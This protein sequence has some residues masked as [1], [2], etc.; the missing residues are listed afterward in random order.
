[1]PNITWYFNNSFLHSPNTRRRVSAYNG[2]ISL[3]DILN[4]TE[5][6]VYSCR[7]SGKLGSLRSHD[8]TV[9]VFGMFYIEMYYRD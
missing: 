4:T 5:P 6:G 8:N 7:A 1:M 9:N 2:T 3:R